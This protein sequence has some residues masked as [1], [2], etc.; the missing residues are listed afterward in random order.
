M[1]V[2]TG[3]K[4]GVAAFLLRAG[5]KARTESPSAR[6]QRRMLE[7]EK[8]EMALLRQAEAKLAD[9]ARC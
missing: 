3:G 7:A 1:E 4:G 9:D 2:E 5:L 6:A 8:A